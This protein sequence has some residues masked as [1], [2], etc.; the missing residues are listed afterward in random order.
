ML[1]SSIVNLFAGA[2]VIHIPIRNSAHVLSIHGCESEPSKYENVVEHYGE[3]FVELTVGA[4][5]KTYFS[6]DF[7][8]HTNALMDASMG[9]ELDATS[10]AIGQN[11]LKGDFVKRLAYDPRRL[12]TFHAEHG[13]VEKIHEKSY[14]AREKVT[15]GSRQPVD[16]WFH[17]AD[18]CEL[19]NSLGFALSPLESQ[20]E[21][22][23]MNF[24]QCCKHQGLTQSTIASFLFPRGMN[25]QGSLVL[26]GVDHS[27]YSG[28]LGKMQM[29][30]SRHGEGFSRSGA[31][32]VVLDGIFGHGEAIVNAHYGVELTTFSWSSLPEV[33]L[34]AIADAFGGEFSHEMAEFIF[35]SEILSTDEKLTFSFGGVP[36]SVPI[37]ELAYEC[38]EDTYCLSLSHKADTQISSIGL[39]V[40]KHAYLVIDYENDEVALA[41]AA[42]S[43]WKLPSL[44]EASAGI[45]SATQAPGYT[46]RAVEFYGHQ[47]S[48]ETALSEKSGFF[49]NKRATSGATAKTTNNGGTQGANGGTTTRKTETTSVHGNTPTDTGTSGEIVVITEMSTTRTTRTT[50]RSS[51]TRNTTSTSSTDGVS[52]MKINVGETYCGVSLPYLYTVVI[53][54]VFLMYA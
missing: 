35:T 28:A 10:V 19:R 33:H 31:I 54:G 4:L 49:L 7:L 44:E 48:P 22:A 13:D 27:K 18:T 36:I 50:R 24:V 32:E 11:K 26:G 2:L 23:E 41:Q 52:P 9:C 5:K 21:N 37:R 6:I 45:P 47:G 46:S 34:T 3:M 14:F 15:L 53:A 30:N 38:A 40:L 25:D 29:V 51:S 17:M 12:G 1:L 16:A 43:I 20:M 42:H 8:H 39:D